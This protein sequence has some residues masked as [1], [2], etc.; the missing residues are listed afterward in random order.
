MGLSALTIRTPEQIIT[1]EAFKEA[2]GLVNPDIMDYFSDESPTSVKSSQSG[3]RE[4]KV[5]YSDK[6]PNTEGATRKKM[7]KPKVV[8]RLLNESPTKRG[9]TSTIK[10][11]FPRP[12]PSGVSTKKLSPRIPIGM[13]HIKIYGTN[14]IKCSCQFKVN[15]KLVKEPKGAY[16]YHKKC[17]GYFEWNQIIERKFDNET[18]SLNEFLKLSSKDLRISKSTFQ[19]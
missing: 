9:L 12:G 3:Y 8:R 7:A 1:M 10:K 17:R 5:I 19:K 6:K 4:R 2:L 18:V 15:T 16:G 11:A 13:S 14:Y